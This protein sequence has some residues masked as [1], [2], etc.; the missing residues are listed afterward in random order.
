VR[1]KIFLIILYK[2][3]LVVHF[4]DN[5]KNLLKLLEKYCSLFFLMLRI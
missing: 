4:Y 5:K 3:N 1:E 2:A